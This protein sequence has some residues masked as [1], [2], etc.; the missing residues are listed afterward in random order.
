MLKKLAAKTVKMRGESKDTVSE[1]QKAIV[2]PSVK[3]LSNRQKK[4]SEKEN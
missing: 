4:S 1:T 2:A 3:M